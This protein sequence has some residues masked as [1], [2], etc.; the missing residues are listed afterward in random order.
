MEGKRILKIRIL[1]PRPA[2]SG[3]SL[4]QVNYYYLR[5]RP[6]KVLLLLCETSLARQEI[7]QK[8]NKTKFIP[9]LLELVKL[10]IMKIVN[11]NATIGH[12][13]LSHSQSLAS[14]LIFGVSRVSL[15]SRSL[16][17]FFSFLLFLCLGDRLLLLLRDLFSFLTFLSLSES[18]SL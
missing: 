16:L 15:S 2:R 4:S 10:K 1:A 3:L 5:L 13:G 14:S 6:G 9:A 12:F 11:K 7:R 18:L 17:S 8:Y